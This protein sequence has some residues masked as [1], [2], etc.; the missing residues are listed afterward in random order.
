[1]NKYDSPR[2]I[3]R[4]KVQCSAEGFVW[5]FQAIQVTQVRHVAEMFVGRDCTF[6]NRFVLR[7]ELEQVEVHTEVGAHRDAA[8]KVHRTIIRIRDMADDGYWGEEIGIIPLHRQT[9]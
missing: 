5:T 4:N 1:E 9:D 8:G 3:G 6:A 7:R 2:A